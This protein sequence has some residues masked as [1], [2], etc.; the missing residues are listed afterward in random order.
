MSVLILLTILCISTP[1]LK[2]RIGGMLW[3]TTT[4]S[5]RFDSNLN[6]ASGSHFSPSAA[7][8]AILQLLTLHY[9][10]MITLHDKYPRLENY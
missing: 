1:D 5:A 2:Y 4:L 7:I 9:A 6:L 3:S 8:F 10:R